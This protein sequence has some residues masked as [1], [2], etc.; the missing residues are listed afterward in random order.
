ML[1][2]C[3]KAVLN[4]APDEQALGSGPFIKVPF[5]PRLTPDEQALGSGPFLKVYRRLEALSVDDDEAEVRTPGN[6]SGGVGMGGDRAR[7][8][9]FSRRG[10][11]GRWKGKSHL[12]IGA[13]VEGGPRGWCNLG[14]AAIHLGGRWPGPFFFFKLP[15][16]AQS[17]PPP[18]SRLCRSAVSSSTCSARRSLLT[19]GWS[20]S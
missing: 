13:R 19:W 1:E 7:G 9:I 20:T 14:Q 5:T 10:G 11:G 4:F 6:K 3:I 18:L 2:V 15:P 12:C 16:S 8:Y 17:P